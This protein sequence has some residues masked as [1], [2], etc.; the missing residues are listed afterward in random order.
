VTLVAELSLAALAGVLLN[1]TPCVLPA[2]PVKIRTI[3]RES[4]GEA[5]HRAAAAAAFAAGSLVFFLALGGLTAWLHWSWGSLF[6]SRGFLAFLVVLLAGFALVTYR[7]VSIPVPAFAYTLRGHRYLEPALA[8]LLG[9]VLATPCAGPFLGGVLAYTLTRPEGVT[10]GIFAAVGV[11]LAQPYIVIL[12]WPRLLGRLPGAGA[13]SL[14][15]RQ[16]LAFVL[17]AAAVFFA[18]SLVGSVAAQALWIA[19]AALFVFW[20]GAVTLRDSGWRSR[21][22]VGAFVVLAGGGA[23]GLATGGA[24]GTIGWQPYTPARAARA[25]AAGR[26]QLIE[27]TADWCINCKV[28]ERTTYDDPGVRRALR[29]SHTVALRADLTRADPRLSQALNRFGGAA[30]PFAVVVDG[31]GR[32]VQRFDGMFGAGA[33]RAALREAAGRNDADGAGAA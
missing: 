16:G 18:G 25:A 3:L 30:L 2:M 27:F 22:V 24:P 6:Q 29:A 7:D 8:G 17:L 12:L 28:L 1:L 10:L 33:L 20:A 21:A 23:L 15:V 9:A 14:R 31:G 11:G 19:W 26:P 4:G 13:W 5:S 32:V